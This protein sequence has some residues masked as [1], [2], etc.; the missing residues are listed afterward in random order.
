MATS[1][2]TTLATLALALIVL[3]SL[4]VHARQQGAPTAT[5]PTTPATSTTLITGAAPIGNLNEV[6]RSILFPNANVIFNVQLED[7]GEVK[8]PAPNAATGFSITQWGNGLYSNWEVVSYAAVALE[9]SAY[10][11]N[12]PGRLF[13]NGKPVPVARADWTKFTT[14]LSDTAKAVYAASQAKNRDTVIELT[15]RLNDA[16]QSCHGVYRRGN[17]VTRCVAPTP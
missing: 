2:K 16:C 5:A 9:E 17:D 14:E 12:K 11:L 4:A 8:P 7:P 15:D 10:F 13:Q 1:H 3:S 6:M